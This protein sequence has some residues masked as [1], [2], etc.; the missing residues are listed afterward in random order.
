MLLLQSLAIEK[1]AHTERERENLRDERRVWSLDM[2][3]ELNSL[4]SFSSLLLFPSLFSGLPFDFWTH[5]PH[6]TLHPLFLSL[7]S[8]ISLRLIPCNS[9]FL[10][11]FSS[12]S[13]SIAFH[14]EKKVRRLREGKKSPSFPVPTLL[15]PVVSGLENRVSHFLDIRLAFSTDEYIYFFSLALLSLFPSSSFR[16][17]S[18]RK[19]RE[20]GESFLTRKKGRGRPGR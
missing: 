13:L 20:W 15:S 18:L 10:S 2:R 14:R 7:L 11:S 5:S 16:F 12:F 3:R 17:Y 1:E 8:T 6:L 19:T 9:L 4:C